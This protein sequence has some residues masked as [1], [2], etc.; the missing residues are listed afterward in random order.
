MGEGRGILLSCSFC[1]GWTRPGR[2]GLLVSMCVRTGWVVPSLNTD[3][4][5]W[6]PGVLAMPD[7]AALPLAH[8]RA[9]DGGG[10]CRAGLLHPLEGDG[11]PRSIPGWVGTP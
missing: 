8:M 2:V 4:H 7:W 11:T 3:W 6:E 10:L 5:A 9:K 1:W